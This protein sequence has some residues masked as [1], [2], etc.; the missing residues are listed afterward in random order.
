[1]TSTTANGVTPAATAPDPI[2]TPL[3]FP[4]GL[5]IKNRV[6][7]SNI[8]GRIDNYDGSGT[9]ARVNWEEQ[10]ARGG[11]GAIVSSHVPIHARGRVLP[12][13]AL[14]DDDDKIPFWRVVGE[15]VHAHDCKFLLQLSH[16]GRQ[17][18]IAGVENAHNIAL[19]ST[20]TKDPI[21]GLPAHAMDKTEIR[22]VV[23]MFGHGARR[24]REAGLDGVELHACNGY[25]FT[26]FLSSAINDRDDEYGG[27]L[28]NRARFLLEVIEAIQREAGKDFHLQIKVSAVDH[29]DAI[30]PWAK[31]GNTLADS[32]Q[33]FQWAEQAG[34]HAVHVS[35]GNF[36]P[37]PLNPAGDFSPREV[38]GT[39]DTML[40]SGSHTLRNYILWR[41]KPTRPLGR[42]IWQRTVP[43]DPEGQLLP[44]AAEVRR[45]LNIPVIVTGGFQTASVVRQALEDGHCDAV[46][47]ARPLMANPDLVN[48]WA[49]GTD[50]AERP[51]SYC[52]LCLFHAPEDPL[53]CY[54]ERRFDS[55]DAMIA[56]VMSI[57]RPDGWTDPWPDTPNKPPARARKPRKVEAAA[58]GE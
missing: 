39:Y 56:Q 40:S 45:H 30:F 57:Y 43:Q 23:A 33:V 12:N 9:M 4:S 27:P 55:H 49:T 53:G 37:H 46:S 3:T 1:V 10:F 38:V 8:S 14:I 17:R 31:K 26:Q 44:E 42:W 21:H 2:F 13:Y 16:S 22:Q 20:N 47:I 51:C 58:P 15:R 50:R 35:T 11:V 34:V 36:F 48:Q 7:R 52:N 54:D 24:A 18:D 28:E 41:L 32:I 25:L 29:G 6:L 19:S 5:T